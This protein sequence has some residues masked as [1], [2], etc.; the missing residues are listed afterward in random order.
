MWTTLGLRSDFKIFIF[1]DQ[2]EADSDNITDASNYQTNYT[3]LINKIKNSFGTCCSNVIWINPYVNSLLDPTGTDATISG[4]TNANPIVITTQTAHGL[5]SGRTVVITGVSGN[6]AANG[7]FVITVTSTTKFSIPIA[8]NGT[9][10]SGGNVNRFPYSSTVISAQQNVI[11]ALSN[12][13]GYAT[14][15]YVTSEGV[16]YTA[17]GYKDKGT[18]AVNNIIIPNNL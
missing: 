10:T 9:Y 17:T 4:A 3:S 8:G 7:T 5:T 12:C 11:G 6:T 18:Y 2:G 1:W 15:S 16:H 13:Y 14:S